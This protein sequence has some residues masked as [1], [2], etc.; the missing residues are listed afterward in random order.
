[1]DQLSEWPQVYA[2]SNQGAV[3]V[4]DAVGS[5]F[6]SRSGVPTK[7]H[8]DQSE[9]LESLSS[10]AICLEYIRRKDF[11]ASTARWYGKAL[12]PDYGSPAYHLCQE[13]SEGPWSLSTPCVLSLSS[14]RANLNMA[15]L[16]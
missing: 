4:A 11:P 12:K 14:T 10:Q 3:T 1:M 5:E 15:P 2:L 6:S 7:L 8:S 9:S 16:K 13:L